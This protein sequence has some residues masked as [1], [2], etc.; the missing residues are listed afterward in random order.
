MGACFSAVDEAKEE[1]IIVMPPE[2]CKKVLEMYGTFCERLKFTQ[3]ET[4]WMYQKYK[5]VDRHKRGMLTAAD[6]RLYFEVTDKEFGD[7]FF[8]VWLQEDE[9]VVSMVRSMFPAY[10]LV[11]IFL[12]DFKGFMFW[13]W[14]IC[15]ASR[16]ELKYFL[17]LTYDSEQSGTLKADDVIA[18]FQDTFGKSW[19]SHRGAQA[20]IPL[21]LQTSLHLEYVTEDLTADKF[22][23]LCDRADILAYPLF[24]VMSKIIGL[25]GGTRH[26]NMKIAT[27]R[28]ILQDKEAVK[29]LKQNL[30]ELNGNKSKLKSLTILPSGVIGPSYL[31]LT[32]A[33]ILIEKLKRERF[34]NTKAIADDQKETGGVSPE[35]SQVSQISFASAPNPR[36][37][38]VPK[39]QRFQLLRGGFSQRNMKVS[40]ISDKGKGPETRVGRSTSLKERQRTQANKNVEAM[41]QATMMRR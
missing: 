2:E 28:Q 41:R 10:N 16:S 40:P 5:R 36:T 34:K 23:Y 20:I 12:Q 38:G 14:N 6:L 35:G 25:L 19:E 32:E 39:S 27:K 1:L 7:K 31:S 33:E 13:V 4:L 21:F 17:Y 15:T 18:I 9:Y 26:W 29:K 3:R 8:S 37:S 22:A 11:A 24:N 30:E